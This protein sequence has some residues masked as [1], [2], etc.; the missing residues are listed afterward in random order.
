MP[1]SFLTTAPKTHDG[2]KA[3]SSKNVDGKS[4][5]QSAKN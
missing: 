1:T 2:E 5:Y 3:A 4:G